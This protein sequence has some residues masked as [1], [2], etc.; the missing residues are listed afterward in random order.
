MSV[1][2]VSNS[3]RLLCIYP[4][5]INSKKTIA[6]G[7]RICKSKCC[8]NPTYN[9]MKDVC[10]AAGFKPVVENKLYPRELYRGDALV[11]GR[12][13]VDLKKE[14]GSLINESL[15][16]KKSLM[17]HLGEMIPK[18]KSRSAKGAESS[19]HQQQPSKSKKNKRR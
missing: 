17:I 5:Y 6:E 14:D 10:I 19:G 18:L 4:A 15:P 1:Q 7:R 8:D 13:R 12:I 11:R 9:E 16:D 3:D 2:A